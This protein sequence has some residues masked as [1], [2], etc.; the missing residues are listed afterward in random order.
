M[1]FVDQTLCFIVIEAVVGTWDLRQAAWLD[2]DVSVCDHDMDSSLHDWFYWL[3]HEHISGR[4][5]TIRNYGKASGWYSGGWSCPNSLVLRNPT[6][7]FC[8]HS[9][10]TKHFFKVHVTITSWCSWIIFRWTRLLWCFVISPCITVR[11]FWDT[12]VAITARR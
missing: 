2:A 3:R 1:A 9:I 12:R 6:A 7:T 4:P 10:E 11:W 5:I 8:S